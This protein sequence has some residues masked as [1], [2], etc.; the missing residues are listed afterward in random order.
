MRSGYKMR[1][2]VLEVTMRMLRWLALLVV[3]AGIASAQQPPKAFPAADP[4]SLDFVRSAIPYFKH[5][6]FGFEG[7]RIAWGTLE[8]P[9]L[10]EFGDRV[11]IALL[12]IYSREELVQPENANACLSA[13]RTAFENRISVL[14]HSDRQPRVT[15]FLLDYLQENEHSNDKLAKRIKYIRGCVKEFT[16]SSQREGAFFMNH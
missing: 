10:N 12:K 16:C 2:T 6:G 14:D 1:R 11:S 4:Y 7:K 8:I 9:G 15:V 13:I 5:G 3:G